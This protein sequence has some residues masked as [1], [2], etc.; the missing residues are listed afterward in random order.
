MI[1]TRQGLYSC[2]TENA[3]W[4][5]AQLEILGIHEWP[6]QG[7]WQKTVIGKD[8][9]EEVLREFLRLRKVYREDSTTMDLDV[10][11][12]EYLRSPHWL[13]FKEG[14]FKRHKGRCFVTDTYL[15]IDLH[16]ITYKNLGAEKDE[17]V[18]PLCHSAHEFVHRL[19]KEYGVPLEQAHLVLF[20]SCN[21]R[22]EF[23]DQMKDE[24]YR[25]GEAGKEVDPCWRKSDG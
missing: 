25:F 12:A 23:E 8:Y 10:Q 24:L 4:T 13:A 19:I 17:D 7:N 22:E 21:W 3:G 15:N 2:R 20:F 11:H 9:P 1:L 18:V 14:Y 5:R 16:H 6:P